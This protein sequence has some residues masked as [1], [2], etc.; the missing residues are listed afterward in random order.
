MYSVEGMPVVLDI[1]SDEDEGLKEGPKNS[2]LEW[3]QELL[4][5]SD[6]EESN[7]DSDDVVILHETKPQ[8]HFKSKAISTLSVNDGDDDD[9]DCVVLEGDP[10]N[11]V[12]SV[13]DEGANGSDELLVVGE[14]GQ[15][16]S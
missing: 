9:D 4:F 1:S 3:I 5:N 13:D 14:K 11:G 6:D 8:Q 10:E 15:V 7:A 12:T 16:C 2:D